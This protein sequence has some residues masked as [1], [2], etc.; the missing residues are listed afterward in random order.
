MKK[1]LSFAVIIA[2]LLAGCNQSGKKIPANE[3][4]AIMWDM[5]CA[6]ELY[7]EDSLVRI[8]KDNFRLYEQVFA[9]H[10]ISKEAFYSSLHY[11][12]SH[13]DD[14]KLLMDSLQTYSNQ[15][16]LKSIPAPP[17]L[18]KTDKNPQ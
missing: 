2:F 16:K 4:K 13:P 6:D 12:Q 14:L 7:A 5:V 1:I 8:K 18:P 9:A 15:Q 17:A 3:M 11:Y 10:K